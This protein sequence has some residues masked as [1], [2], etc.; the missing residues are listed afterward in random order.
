MEVEAQ[1][2]VQGGTDFCS[3]SAE[4]SREECHDRSGKE[5]AYFHNFDVAGGMVVVG[6]AGLGRSNFDQDKRTW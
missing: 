2:A 1:V 3:R 4:D 6:F 5:K